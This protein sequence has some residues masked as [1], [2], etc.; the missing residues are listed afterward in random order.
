L[1]FGDDKS[2]GYVFEGVFA[3]VEFV[4]D[5]VFVLRLTEE[6]A[7]LR[8]LGLHFDDQKSSQNLN[9]F[10]HE[11]LNIVVLDHFLITEHLKKRL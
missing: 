8:F 4:Q 6:V 2:T 5:T 3:L 7:V 10:E 1:D 9:A 11:V